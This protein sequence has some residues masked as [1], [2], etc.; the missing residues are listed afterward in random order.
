MKRFLKDNLTVFKKLH[1]IVDLAL[2]ALALSSAVWIDYYLTSGNLVIP[3]DLEHLLVLVLPFWLVLLLSSKEFYEYRLKAL[4]QIIKDVGLVVIKSMG[5]LLALLFV[6]KSQTH[7]RLF[8][9]SLA[10]L[11]FLFLL[12]MRIAIAT[13]LS[14][15]RKRGYNFKAILVV[16]S[17]KIASDF[18]QEVK[19]HPQW[20]FKLLGIIDW[21]E[22]RKG[23]RVLNV[24]IIGTLEDL[25][26]LAKNNHVDY[27]V[28]AVS[29][30]YLNLVEESVLTCEEMGVTACILADFFPLKF[31]KKKMT[32]FLDKPMILFTT[33]PDKYWSILFKYLFD[34]LVALAGIIL[35]SPVM[36]VTA[37]L[38]KLSSKGPILFKQDRCGLNGR[39][40]ILYKFR[41]MVENAE[42]LKASLLDKN[43]M[44]GPVFKLTDDP[45]L[46][47]IGKHLRKFSLD[48]L[49]QLFNVLFGDMSLVGPRPPLPSEVSQY[50]H[51]QR[52][53]L[54][55]KPGITCLWQV[56]GRNNVNFQEWMKLDL[57]YIDNWSLRL[58]T[59]IL[60]KTIPAVMKGTGAK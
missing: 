44:D 49:P 29:K 59:K 19:K 28:Y 16:G 3:L 25:P 32:Q 4:G 41:T 47:K 5:L 52:R 1:F 11:D 60:F 35:I 31:S 45:R 48:E 38:V 46:T 34:R 9:G 22:E 10:L 43:E 8:L 55:M 23:R 6:T 20:G 13:T 57:Q 40:F 27:V 7:S 58:D 26:N 24:P 18:I 50:D 42:E 54:S 21:E 36:L 15:V 2:T 30:R 37:I 33:T 14:Y 53:K 51:W 56:N 17:G 12:G 39:R